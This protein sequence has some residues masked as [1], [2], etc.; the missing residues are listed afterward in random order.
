MKTRILLLAAFVSSTFSGA[1]NASQV[2]WLDSDH[3]SYYGDQPIGGSVTFKTPS[4]DAKV[5][6]W[7]IGSDNKIYQARLGVWESGIGVKN[8]SN[9]NSH[10]IDNSGS[11]DFIVIQFDKLVQLANAT[12]NTGWHG[13]NDT[14][15][16][17]G[18]LISGAPFS[19]TVNLTGA[20]QS[21]LSSYNLFESGGNGYSGN[22]VRPINP[23]GNV[24]NTW[25]IGASFNNPDG[26]YKL[27]GFKLEKL[28][29]SVAAVPEPSTWMF[30]LLGMTGVGYTMRRKDKQTLRVR[31]T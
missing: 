28:S 12:F 14:D 13:F 23:N 2:I 31:Y 10:T 1:A 6:A 11:R 25:L 9:D 3:S 29:F 19:T 30:M 4:A 21:T 5:T 18:Y 27:D 8:G 16:T 22:S 26:S 7:S 15:A 20:N 24:G 17:I